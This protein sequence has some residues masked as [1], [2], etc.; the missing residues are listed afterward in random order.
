MS[1]FCILTLLFI[2]SINMPLLLP[3]SLVAYRMSLFSIILEPKR[4]RQKLFRIQI[5]ICLCFPQWITKTAC[6]PSE[7][8]FLIDPLCFF[9]PSTT[10]RRW[11]IANWIYE[12]A[13]WAL[14]RNYRNAL[15]LVFKKIE[16][17]IE[18]RCIQ[19]FLLGWLS[20]KLCHVFETTAVLLI[21]S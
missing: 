10:C 20:E 11:Q 3:V 2:F 14:L 15:P 6:E 16:P 5:I 21:C 8:E 18:F 9:L 7:I 12:H 1:L 4:T 19:S 13:L 17:C